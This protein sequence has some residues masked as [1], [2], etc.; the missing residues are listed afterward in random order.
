LQTQSDGRLG[1]VTPEAFV[2]E[3]ERCGAG[4]QKIVPHAEREDA[5][6]ILPV[7]PGIFV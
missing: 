2:P 4:N 6:Q 5:E 7:F 1:L 3:S